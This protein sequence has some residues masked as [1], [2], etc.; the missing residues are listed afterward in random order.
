MPELPEVEVVRRQIEP[1]LVGRTIRSVRTTRATHFF[2]TPPRAL[3]RRLSG[4][5]V[6]ALARRGK[7]LLADLDDASRLLLHLGMTGQLFATGAASLRLL[8]A[9]RRAALAP[10]EQ[11]D[12][13]RDAHTHLVLSF[14]D[15]GPEI[16]FRDVRRFGRVLWLAPGE[17]HARLERL[18]VDALAV[19]GGPLFAATRG[20]TASIKNLLLD[21]ATIAGVGN[22]YADEALFLAGVRPVRRAGR[23]S[24][25]DCGRIAES[26]RRVLLRSIETGGSS[27][28][29]YVAPDGRDGAYQDER[30]VYARAGE[31]CR[32]CDAPI[33][34]VVI[35]QRSSHYCPSCQR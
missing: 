14:R 22:I 19:E 18:G 29:D 32:V 34:R 17:S 26:L 23:L 4:R 7:Y 31:P 8:S 27:M 15:G 5:R 3:A 16:L 21:Q 13:R 30:R 10:E 6:E 25:A 33:R 1:L 20:R 24:R 35:G 28:S 12:F 2:L 11:P 9:A